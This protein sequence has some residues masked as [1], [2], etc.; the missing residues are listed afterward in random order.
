MSKKPSDVEPKIIQMVN[1]LKEDKS[2]VKEVL[3]EFKL[4][5]D[6]MMTEEALGFII[7]NTKKFNAIQKWAKGALADLKNAAE[8]EDEYEYE[9]EEE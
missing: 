3:M 5:D 4:M 9:D 6:D 8:D 1:S 7:K 2:L